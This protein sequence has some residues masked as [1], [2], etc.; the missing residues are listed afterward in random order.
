MMQNQGE[1][2]TLDGNLYKGRLPGKFLIEHFVGKSESKYPRA[3]RIRIWVDYK[4][5]CWEVDN[6]DFFQ[7]L[8]MLPIESNIASKYPDG[9]ILLGLIRDYL[10]WRLAHP[11]IPP[12]TNTSEFSWW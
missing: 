9:F 2:F 7:I 4:F 12:N 6:I 5:T 3:E 1:E 10:Y 8:L 11:E